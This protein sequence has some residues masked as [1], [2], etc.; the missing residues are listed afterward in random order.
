M[1][2]SDTVLVRRHSLGLLWIGVIYAYTNYRAVQARGGEPL[3]WFMTWKDYW[4]VVYASGITITF[5]V[6]FYLT[7]RIDEFITGR[8]ASYFE[9]KPTVTAKKVG[10]KRNKLE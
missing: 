7:A 1:Y 9:V 6:I 3:Y 10:N 4:S 5:C 2:V 8:S